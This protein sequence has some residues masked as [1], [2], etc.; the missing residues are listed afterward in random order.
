MKKISLIVILFFLLFFYPSIVL[1]DELQNKPFRA[2]VIKVLEEKNIDHENGPQTVQQN[3]LLLGLD[4]EYRNKEIIFNGIGIFDLMSVGNYRAGDKVYVD[5]IVNSDGEMS[6]F[7]VDY[8]RT[9]Q[10]IWLLI[11][12]LLVIV[13]ISGIKGIRSLISLILSFG[14]ILLI[15]IPL[16]LKGFDPVLVAAFGSFLVLM[17]IIYI[18]EGFNKKSHLAVISIFLS[19]LITLLLSWIFVLWSRLSGFASEEAT[20]LASMMIGSINFQGLL[21]AGIL[22]GSLGVLDDIVVGQIEA[23]AQ[24]KEINPNLSISKVFFSAYKIGNTHLGAIVNTLFL[25]YA[26]VSLPLLAMFHLGSN[27]GLDFWQIINN[28]VIA[29]EII[30]TL[31][32]AIGL[33]L[34]MPLAT[35]LASKFLNN[36]K[37]NN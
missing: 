28:D 32:G 7:V 12:F 31:V 35:Y 5:H 1:A 30:R 25:T 24:I 9:G 20:L 33:I 15:I 19:L 37:S 6:F 3:L 21:L 23:V 13:I 34:S 36:K 26:G 17:A 22:I 11:I 2:E 27:Q 16:I 4:G 18:T 29:T 14:V 10:L 8:I